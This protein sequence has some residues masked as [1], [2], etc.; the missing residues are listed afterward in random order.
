MRVLIVEPKKEPYVKEIQNDLKS[1]QEVVGGYI[2]IIEIDKNIVIVDNEEGKCIPLDGNRRIGIDII[3]GTFF[4]CGSDDNGNLLSL[5]DNEI[6]KY[7]ERFKEPKN[8][9][10]EEVEDAFFIEIYNYEVD[11]EI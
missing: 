6:E 1:M 2:E 8:Y 3:A 9:T 4:V 10:P 7:Y 11:K 5:T